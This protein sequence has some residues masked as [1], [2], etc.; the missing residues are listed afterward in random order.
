MLPVNTK[1]F[2]QLWKGR[3]DKS[4][5]TSSINHPLPDASD[6]NNNTTMRTMIL[7]QNVFRPGPRDWQ[8]A[9]LGD[10][11]KYHLQYTQ[12]SLTGLLYTFDPFTCLKS[13]TLVKNC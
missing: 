8:L 7:V 5:L 11:T 6:T 9:D 12:M 1:K 3:T 10:R 4:S 2:P 13:S